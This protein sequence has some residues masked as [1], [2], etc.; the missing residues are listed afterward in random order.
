M[1]KIKKL[2]EAGV[3]FGHQTRRWNPKMEKYIFGKKNGIHIIDLQK[4][5]KALNSAR[6]FLLNLASQG[7]T[8]LFVGTKKQANP[9]VKDE[10]KRCGMFYIC[11]RWLGGLLTN[12]ATIKKS[13]QRYKDLER[14]KTDG[15]FDKLSKKEV[16]RLL[17]EMEKLHKNLEGVLEMEKLPQALFVVD[18][19]S[20]DIAIREAEKLSIPVCGLVDT[21]CD[22]DKI[23]YPIPGN[24]D[25]IKSIRLIASML[26]D[27][28]IE[29]RRCFLDYLGEDL[30]RKEG[31]NGQQDD[32][33][34]KDKS[35][36]NEAENVSEKDSDRAEKEEIVSSE[37]QEVNND[38]EKDGKEDNEEKE[39]GK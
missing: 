29:G 4:T 22:P 16:S 19:K 2:L 37:S 11:H 27:T 15:T 26:A 38:K 18:T 23:D 21:N 35:D 25:A 17:K 10:A 1:E 5:D 39:K 20:E 28:I 14:M 12:F 31:E 30:V 24:D 13:I 32:V 8:V 36:N 7:G 6:E 3:H 33:V 9:A 34:G